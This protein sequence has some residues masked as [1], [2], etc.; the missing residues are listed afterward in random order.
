MAR[1]PGRD[2][3]SS[4]TA[5]GPISGSST[6]DI[7]GAATLESTLN[8][9]GGVTVAKTAATH[10][11]SAGVVDTQ[12]VR[13]GSVTYTFAST[14]GNGATAILT[15]SSSIVTATDVILLTTG[16]GGNPNSG[17]NAMSASVVPFGAFDGGFKFYFTNKSGGTIANDATVIVNWL[18]L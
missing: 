10:D 11:F 16:E 3:V 18:A 13:A 14:L 4:V 9:T 12:N 1:T 7:V 2:N 6:L 17:A 8:V 15:I 5:A